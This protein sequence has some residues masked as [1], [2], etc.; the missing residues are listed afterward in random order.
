MLAAILRRAGNGFI[1]L[2]QGGAS[3]RPATLRKSIGN[4]TIRL[5]IWSWSEAGKQ[6]YPAPKRAE[7]RDPQNARRVI[8]PS[9]YRLPWVTDS[10]FVLVLINALLVSDHY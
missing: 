1:K 6:E 10:S 5:R 7:P 8:D 2:G 3:Q 9:V 4:F